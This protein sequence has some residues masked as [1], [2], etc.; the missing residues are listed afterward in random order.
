MNDVARER[1]GSML[2]PP[3]L[4]EL[5]CESMEDLGWDVMETAARLRCNR[6]SLSHLLNGK[7]GSITF[8]CPRNRGEDIAFRF[9]GLAAAAI[10]RFCWIFGSASPACGLLSR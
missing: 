10:S 6:V 8:V 9:G 3:H 7:I 1:V 5:I 4:G 2:N